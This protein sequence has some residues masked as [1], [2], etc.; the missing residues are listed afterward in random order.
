[1]QRANVR[2]E[3]KEL[4]RRKVLDVAL[5]LFARNGIM[6][7]T[8]A[9]VAKGAGVS[10]GT[11]FSHFGTRDELVAAVIGRFGIAV[12]RRMHELGAQGHGVRDVL[13][14][15]LRG[16]AEHEAFYTRLVTEGHTLPEEARTALIAI[17]SAMS[18][19]L[20]AVAQKD[21]DA[22]VIR[23]MPAHLLFNTWIG[24]VHHYITNADLFAPGGS[25]L[26]RRGAELLE[27]YAGLLAP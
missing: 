20:F 19:H 26:E 6:A 4:T 25:V 8:T 7:T 9:H 13:C 14:A 23:R 24:L 27:H 12:T 17:Q 22:G 3:Q 2:Q 10:H 5:D 21:M 18:F 16:L 15:H 1:M 11:V